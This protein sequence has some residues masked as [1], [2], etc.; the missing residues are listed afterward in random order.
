VVIFND[1]FN[2][3]QEKYD[4][5]YVSNNSLIATQTL[6][7]DIHEK[8]VLELNRLIDEFHQFK[9]IT[10]E[11]ENSENIMQLKFTSLDENLQ[12]CLL[13][14][15]IVS[16]ERSVSYCICIYVYIFVNIYLYIYL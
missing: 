15:S 10:K 12:K 13:D 2:V 6:E 9:M 14:L 11:A 8:T 7:V 5:L 16:V 1:N 4:I 3:L